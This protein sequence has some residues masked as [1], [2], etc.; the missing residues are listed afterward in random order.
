[1]RRRQGKNRLG[2]QSNRCGSDKTARAVLAAWDKLEVPTY[3]HEALPTYSY[4]S[5]AIQEN[6]T[7]VGPIQA[8]GSRRHSDP[9]S[10][11]CCPSAESACRDGLLQR[12][13]SSSG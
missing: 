9:C 4:D 3:R 12:Q 13:P 6:T 11:Q 5:L 2:A 10:T 8:M 7:V 1:M